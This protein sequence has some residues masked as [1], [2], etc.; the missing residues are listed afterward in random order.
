MRRSIASIAAVLALLGQFCARAQEHQFSL[1]FRG[2]YTTTSKIFTNPDSPSP[3]VR[4]QYTAIDNIYSPGFELRWLIPG[5]PVAISL[6]AEYLSRSDEQIQLVGFLNPP[7]ALPVKEG[8]RLI[9]IELG[10]II[11]VPLGGD[12]VRLTLG[13]GVGMYVGHRYLTIAGV[14]APQQNKPISYGIHVETSFDYRITPRIFARLDMRFRD[15]EYITESRFQQ[16]ATQYG[17]VLIRLPLDP[18][19]AKINVN[20]MNFGLGAGFELF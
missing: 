19:R 8:L 12:R 6:A 5:Q 17:G 3:D 7:R 20:G 2:G 9:P 16:E 15:P 4:G 14:E 13:G 18:F 11:F 10:A 1:A